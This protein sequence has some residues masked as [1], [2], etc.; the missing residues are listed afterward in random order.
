MTLEEYL[1]TRKDATPEDLESIR[2]LYG[3]LKSE[4][5]QNLEEF[6]KRFADFDEIKKSLKEIE[7]KMAERKANDGEGTPKEDEF[8]TEMRSLFEKIKSGEDCRGGEFKPVKMRAAAVMTLAGAKSQ[9]P[10][11]VKTTIDK[12]I[13]A[14]NEVR[15]GVVA[16]LNR[17]ASRTAVTRYTQLN[18]EEGTAAITAEGAL[19]PLFSTT[20]TNAE[21]VSKKIAVRIKVSE[22]FEDFTEF[23]SD[24]QMRA[25]RSLTRVIENKVVNGAGGTDLSGILAAGGA[26][27]FSYTGLNGSVA[28]P[29]IVDAILAMC[30]QVQAFGYV[31]NVVFLN[32]ADYAKINFEKDA[33]GRTLAAE[34]IA[35]LQGITLVPVDS[36]TIAAGT[37][38]VMDDGYWQLFVNDVMIREGYGIQKI[39]S[40]YYSDLEVNQRTIIFETFVKSYCPS[41]EVNSMCQGVLAT[42]MATIEKV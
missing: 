25:K 41:T 7:D 24:L 8:T 19:K 26:P 30:T 34:N 10:D 39:G 2:E 42:V 18:T 40:E 32:F 4:T 31:P 38:L 3:V 11:F 1:K 36:N 14:A 37:A 5:D 22:E 21:A 6:K 35:R 27:S 28:T 15:M 16:R 29:N 33:D 12:R 23:M 13:H 17:G 20:Y 9:A